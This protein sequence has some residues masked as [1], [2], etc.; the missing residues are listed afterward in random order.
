MALIYKVL[1]PSISTFETPPGCQFVHRVSAPLYSRV[2]RPSAPTSMLLFYY[3]KQNFGGAF[4]P[5]RHRYAAM[6]S[7]RVAY[8][9][10]L[11]P[12]VPLPRG[13]FQHRSH[14]LLGSSEN[15]KAPRSR[16][17]SEGRALAARQAPHDFQRT[18]FV[19]A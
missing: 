4:S 8:L 10:T 2:A 7:R 18:T 16:G 17:R 12:F 1:L 11:C 3:Y 13:T 6:D 5:T 19:Y 14:K 15:K 9:F